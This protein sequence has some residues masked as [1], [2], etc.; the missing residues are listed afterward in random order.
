MTEAEWLAA[1]DLEPMLAFL[2]GTGRIADR[3][4]RLFACACMRRAWHLL[5]DERSREAVE[6]AEQ[7]A[8]GVVTREHVRSRPWLGPGGSRATFVG[9]FEARDAAVSAAGWALA[10]AAQA[11]STLDREREGVWRDTYW[12][13]VKRNATPSEAEEQA[14]ATVEGAAAWRAEQQAAVRSERVAHAALIREIFGNPFRPAPAIDPAWL[15][16]NGGT[17]RTLAELAYEHRSLP[18]GHLDPARL[19]LLADALED[20]GCGAA[21]LLAHLRSPGP[22]V[23]GCLALDLVLGKE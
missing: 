20:A 13:A 2:V 6:V 7:F 11:V 18:S 21:E 23:R 16:W 15:A 10:G 14:N 1:T 5:G 9:W 8:D 19:S 17:V 22:H 4:L 3:K 12:A